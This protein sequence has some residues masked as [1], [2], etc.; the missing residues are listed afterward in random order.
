MQPGP[1]VY[2][3]FMYLSDVEEGG[4]TQ[5]DGG[6]T[7]QPKAGKAVLWPATLE[8]QPFDSDSRTHHEALPVLKGVKY[9]ANF[10]IHRTVPL[11]LEPWPLAPAAQGDW[12]LGLL[13]QSLTIGGRTTRAAPLE[14]QR[15]ASAG[16]EGP[17]PTVG[18][19]G[20]GG[21]GL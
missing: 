2:T 10:W 9:A 15:T 1:R 16:S 8:Q 13:W 6:F 7:V 17:P 18:P 20:G 5:F 21:G 4:G 19:R 11:R 12:G 14:R 3:F